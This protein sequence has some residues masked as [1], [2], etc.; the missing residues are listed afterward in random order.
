MCR[1]GVTYNGRHCKF[2]H[3]RQL[4]GK[5]FYMEPKSLNRV[6]AVQWADLHAMKTLG[7]HE[8]RQKAHFCREPKAA[9]T[10]QKFYLFGLSNLKKGAGG[11]SPNGNTSAV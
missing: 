6:K 7:F 2:H 3:Y 11:G 8:K 1:L 4:L 10:T 5:L 9:M